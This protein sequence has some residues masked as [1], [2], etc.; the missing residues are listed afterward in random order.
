M[1]LVRM[2]DTAYGKLHKFLLEHGFLARDGL[3]V[4]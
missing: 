3:A 1:R 4:D 2:R